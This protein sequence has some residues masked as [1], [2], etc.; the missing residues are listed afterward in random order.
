V[1]NT[2]TLFFDTN[3]LVY[4]LSE[5]HSKADQAEE[6]ISHGGF[7]S[8][9]VLNEFTNVARNR[10][11]LEWSDIDSIL[12]NLTGVLEVR[13]LTLAIHE[14]G[15]IL[16]RQLQLSIYDAFIVSAALNCG[17]TVLMSE[18][19]QHGLSIENQLRIENPFA[20]V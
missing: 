6:V 12:S 5:D 8:V 17:C 4:L 15:R 3:V 14:H 2:E 10:L 18:D 9:Q 20:R 19:M 7:I 16:A 1:N 11:Q 13:D